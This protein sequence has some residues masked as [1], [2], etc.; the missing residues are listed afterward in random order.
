LRFG[1]NPRTS[2]CAGIAI[3]LVCVSTFKVRGECILK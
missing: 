3:A 2:P 1:G